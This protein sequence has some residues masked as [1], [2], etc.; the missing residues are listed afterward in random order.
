MNLKQLLES[1][2][3]IYQK[4]EGAVELVNEYKESL[5]LIETEIAKEMG[6][7]GVEK[8]AVNG[9]T[10]W[11]KQDMVPSVDNWDEVYS[12]I[13]SSGRYDLLPNAIK[14]SSFKEMVDAG[15]MV[16]G[17]SIKIF[18]KISFRRK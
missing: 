7:A 11:I 16:P 8:I 12:Y 18:D 5:D 4:K 10:C 2:E 14:K 1:R 15:T 9:I 6:K 13:N 3:Q 17:V